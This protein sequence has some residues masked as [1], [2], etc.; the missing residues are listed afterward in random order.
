MRS[1]IATAARI[2][3]RLAVCVGTLTACSGSNGGGSGAS[4]TGGAAA[5]S[6]GTGDSGNGGGST[7]GTTASSTGGSESTSADLPTCALGEAKITDA[8]GNLVDLAP[9]DGNGLMAATGQT[10][11]YTRGSSKGTMSAQFLPPD[12]S[13]IAL[14][15]TTS[16]GEGLSTSLA[17]TTGEGTAVQCQSTGGTVKINNASPG[18]GDF[19]WSVTCGANDGYSNVTESKGCA[20]G[21]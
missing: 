1:E 18:T 21:N 8:S 4:G 19:A 16:V 2:V 6:G 7:G 17:S 9:G 20:H 3:A 11:Y 5:A 14:G 10:I 15:T 13:D 12:G